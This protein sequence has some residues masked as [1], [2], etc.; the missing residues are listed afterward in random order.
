MK[1]KTVSLVVNKNNV[2]NCIFLNTNSQHYVI[3]MTY[4]IYKFILPP[5]K[6]GIF[7]YIMSP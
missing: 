3:V 5:V 1:Q 2:G 7:K 4:V 6:Q